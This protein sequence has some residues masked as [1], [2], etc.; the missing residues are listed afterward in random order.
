MVFVH[1]SYGEHILEAYSWTLSAAA[2][3]HAIVS[4]GQINLQKVEHCGQRF[5]VC[6]EL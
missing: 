3:Y 6:L 1:V 2:D 5:V 4:H